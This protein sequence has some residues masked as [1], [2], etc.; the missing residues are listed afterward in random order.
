MS[1]SSP[2]LSCSNVT[3]HQQ[4]GAST[5]YLLAP[6]LDVFAEN[7]HRNASCIANLA[8]RPTGHGVLLRLYF[9][10]V[11]VL[12]A[13]R[14]VQREAVKWYLTLGPHMCCALH[15]YE[16]PDASHRRGSI[17]LIIYIR[18]PIGAHTHEHLH[19]LAFLEQ[20]TTCCLPLA[21]L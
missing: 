3:L 2:H 21:H 11:E 5:A 14:A 20:K 13:R 8:S 18:A 10:V 9:A 6:E 7:C 16:N 1:A 15:A 4:R 17:R 19:V 12:H